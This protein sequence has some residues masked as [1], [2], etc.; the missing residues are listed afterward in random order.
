MT[1]YVSKEPKVVKK[2]FLRQIYGKDLELLNQ[3]EAKIFSLDENKSDFDT[4]AYLSNF[5][6]IDILD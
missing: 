4:T 2:E 6:A 5:K 3:P 1:R